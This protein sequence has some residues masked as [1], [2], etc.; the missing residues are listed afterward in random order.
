MIQLQGVLE[1]AGEVQAF[2]QE[3]SIGR[4]SPW[5]WAK[6]CVLRTCSPE[7]LL[8]HKV[9]AGRSRDWGDIESVL[10]RQHGRLELAQVRRELE[11]LLE[12]KGQPE[13]LTQFDALN[14][15]VTRR[16]QAKP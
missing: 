14:A 10:I 12:L 11:P 2:C 9:F 5:S 1:A 15:T 4:A 8:T 16:L 6:D 7:D 3:R 13:A